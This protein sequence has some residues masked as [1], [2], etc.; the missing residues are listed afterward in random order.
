VNE[1]ALRILTEWSS[2]DAASEL[3]QLARTSPEPNRRVLAFRGLVRVC[4]EGDGPSDARLRLLDDAMKVAR[5]AEEKRLVIAA[6]AEQHAPE[7]IKVLSPCF[8][9]AALV[10]ETCLAT[11]KI[12]AEADPKSSRDLAPALRQV[13]KVATSQDVREK[14]RSI[15]Q[16][17]DP[18]PE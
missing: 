3:L 10:Q 15:L 18:K 8:D 11:V 17:L 16:R 9:D 1:A 14:A 2:I 4:R 13:L 5:S 6:L 12:A 7:T